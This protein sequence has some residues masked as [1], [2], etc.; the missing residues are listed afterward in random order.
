MCVHEAKHVLGHG[1]WPLTVQIEL[2]SLH[3]L[4]VLIDFIVY[5]NQNLT[6]HMHEIL[7]S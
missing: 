1:K 2:Q 3:F 4:A 7:V 5:S 6:V